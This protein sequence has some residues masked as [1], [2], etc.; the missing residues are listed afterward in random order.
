M[1]RPN[2]NRGLF[3][4]RCLGMNQSSCRLFFVAVGPTSSPVFPFF[5]RFRAG[6]RAVR[7]IPC[8]LDMIGGWL[9]GAG[10]SG[11]GVL[12]DPGLSGT[13][14]AAAAAAVVGGLGI[15]QGSSSGPSPVAVVFS[16]VHEAPAEVNVRA[17]M[18]SAQRPYCESC[19]LFV[20]TWLSVFPEV[21]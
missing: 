21:D 11:S 14:V 2:L 4:S 5:V 8:S 16:C 15:L 7:S 18:P 17:G 19:K 12:S 13:R 20:P 10:A 1:N 6:A 9:L 3:L